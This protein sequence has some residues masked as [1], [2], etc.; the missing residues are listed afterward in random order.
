MLPDSLAT[1]LPDDQPAA[2]I[3]IRQS[4]SRSWFDP[5]AAPM[6]ARALW[7]RLA[8]RCRGHSGLFLTL[9]YDPQLFPDPMD[10]YYRSGEEQH[11]PLFLRKL[12]RALSERDEYGRLK[13]DAYDS[14]GRA[15]S[16]FSMSGKWFCKLEFQKNGNIHFHLIILDAPNIP[17]DLMQSLWG[18]GHVWVKRLSPTNMRYCCKYVGKDDAYPPFIYGERVRSVKVVRVSSGFWSG[19]SRRSSEEAERD[20]DPYDVYGPPK[21]ATFW[22][23]GPTN[24]D[25]LGILAEHGVIREVYPSSTAQPGVAATRSVVPMSPAPSRNAR[26]EAAAIAGILDEAHREQTKRALPPVCGVLR[27]KYAKVAACAAAA[28]FA[29]GTLPA[30][31]D[32]PRNSRWISV[33]GT[34]DQVV[35]Q[36]GT[37]DDGRAAGR[38]KAGLHLI[39]TPKHDGVNPPKEGEHPREA[40]HGLPLW[41]VDHVVW[42]AERNS[43]D[44]RAEMDAAM[45]E[46]DAFEGALSEAC[47]P[48]AQ[49]EAWDALEKGAV[50]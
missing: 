15:L 48:L 41:W 50:R 38:L 35:R 10:L 5:A 6:K 37:A 46:L 21:P 1:T 44:C 47:G 11:V 2:I 17:Q 13:T 9:T 16:S 30:A 49:S 25:L 45:R 20:R 29:L 39:H 12:E 32:A 24:D 31:A 23:C 26:D 43:F 19:K 40:F 34:F 3:Q 36:V 18:R 27:P 14:Q 42:D 33:P 28:L 8:A 7:L 22:H 4:A